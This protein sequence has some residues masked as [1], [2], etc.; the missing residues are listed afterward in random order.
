MTNINDFK[1]LGFIDDQGRAD[2]SP[3]KLSKDGD[4]VFLNS[5]VPIE[6]NTPEKP[7]E[8]M[9]IDFQKTKY[10]FV[11]NELRSIVQTAQEKFSTIF[12]W[13]EMMV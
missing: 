9:D 2:E 12:Q 3:K 4:E 1:T 7:S 10:N 6:K 13:C 8:Q 11:E 5:F